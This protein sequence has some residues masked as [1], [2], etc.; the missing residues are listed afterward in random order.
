MAYVIR[1]T[2]GLIG[3]FLFFSQIVG[4]H[5]HSHLI[6]F[7][8]ININHPSTV[9]TSNVL[10]ALYSISN[11]V[12]F[13]QKIFSFCLFKQAG[14]ADIKAFELLL[15]F[16]PV[17]LIIVYF[18]MRKYC[19]CSRRFSYISR[20]RFSNNA[21]THGVCCFLILCFV[22]ITLLA[23]LLILVD[24][25]YANNKTIQ[26]SGILTRRYGLFPHILYAIGSLFIT[27]VV[28]AITTLI[29]IFHPILMR[30]VSVFGWGDS[31]VVS[32]LNQC[33]FVNKL[34][35]IL[36]S[37]QGNYKDNFRC[38]AGLQIFLYRIA[39]FLIMVT[40]PEVTLSLLLLTIF[41]MVITLVH[42]LV[43][44]FKRYID[45]AVYSMIYVLLLGILVVEL[46]TISTTDFINGIIWLLIILSSLPL[47]CFALYCTWRVTRA[48]NSYCSNL[49]PARKSLCVSGQYDI[50]TCM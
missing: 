17:L 15:S 13:N 22:R 6:Y 34:K 11:L 36:D 3:A 41:M 49:T 40:T 29:L 16:Y 2:S 8:N 20:W 25:F 50:Y 21:I 39:F 35:P 32:L 42:I 44:P 18:M 7:I 37:F 30:I 26:K 4:S 12:F 45:N 48:F 14:T 38:F 1:M 28:I 9:D 31:R 5:Y 46:Y 27:V 10:F 47:C 19:H 33:L 24:I 23:F 43:M